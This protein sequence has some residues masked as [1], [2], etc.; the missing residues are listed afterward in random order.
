MK[1]LSYFFGI[2][3]VSAAL[4]LPQCRQDEAHD[5]ASAAGAEARTVT[6]WPWQDAR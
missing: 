5:R 4:T 3:T 1:F 6:A 2:M